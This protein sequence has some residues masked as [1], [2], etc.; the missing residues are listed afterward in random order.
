MKI[1][2]I[3]TISTCLGGIVLLSLAPIISAQY[4]TTT[5][6]P[7]QTIT[8]DKKSQQY[9]E[10]CYAYPIHLN[11]NQK[12]RIKFSVFYENVTATLKI[13]GS[14]SY[15]QYLKENQ[16]NAPQN[17]IGKYFVYSTHNW[18]Q[19]PGGTYVQSVTAAID[20][21]YDIEFMGDG[22]GSGIW[23]EPGD[24]VIIVYGNNAFVNSTEV[25]FNIEITTDGSRDS[26]NTTISSIGCVLLIAAA[27]LLIVSI[28]KE[29]MI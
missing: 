7:A 3:L 22:S 21:S 9:F 12:I 11:L 24:Y 2:R 15:N 17:K 16:T 14:G 23:S 6:L 13:F 5:I 19:N 27:V 29:G 4:E 8:I 28:K 26:I 10:S 25:K 1:F 18:N 20:D